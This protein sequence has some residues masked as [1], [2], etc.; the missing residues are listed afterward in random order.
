MT[1][2][3]SF[4]AVFHK[5]SLESAVTWNESTA[6]VYTQGI[7]DRAIDKT[8]ERLLEVAVEFHFASCADSARLVD[9]ALGVSLSASPA[10]A[11]VAQAILGSIKSVNKVSL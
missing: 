7:Y 10:A 11:F 4:R 8:S 5:K 6:V 9:D 2:V 1:A 3:L